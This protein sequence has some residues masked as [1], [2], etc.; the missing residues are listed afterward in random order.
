M[1]TQ[2]KKYLVN[3]GFQLKFALMLI[4][5][6]LILGSIVIFS[7]FNISRSIL[8]AHRQQ[9]MTQI[10]SL[11]RCCEE[12]DYAYIGSKSTAGLKSSIHNLKFFSRDLINTNA[13]TLGRLNGMVM[14]AM[15][16]FALGLLILGIFYS[17]RI[18]GPI[19]RIERSL[20]NAAD[21]LKVPLGARST[22]EF[23]GFFGSLENMRRLLCENSAK[24]QNVVKSIR[25]I[26]QGIRLKL[27]PGASAEIE[28]LEQEINKIV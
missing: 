26:L 24:N 18:A 11:E 5:P 25:G 19:Y 8:V 9:L 13:F 27:P 22:D 20:K 7:V 14:K 15:L 4:L 23:R 3:W 2:R 6:V 17:H 16:I 28:K 21:C 10:G 12:L 1:G